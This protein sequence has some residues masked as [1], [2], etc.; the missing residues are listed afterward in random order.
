MQTKRR[1]H[2]HIYMCGYFPSHLIRR[3]SCA[4]FHEENCVTQHSYAPLNAGKL[5]LSLCGV[6]CAYVYVSVP[7]NPLRLQHLNTNVWLYMRVCVC[8]FWNFSSC[9]AMLLLLLCSHFCSHVCLL[10][11]SFHLISVVAL[12]PFVFLL[13]LLLWHEYH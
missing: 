13:L 2:I 12:W 1:A 11:T 4:I 8:T 10:P 5:S 3:P 7:H 6:L 9:A